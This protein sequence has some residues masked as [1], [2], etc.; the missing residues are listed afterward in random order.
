MRKN[1]GLK[2]GQTKTIYLEREGQRRC[3]LGGGR[4]A[5]FSPETRTGNGNKLLALALFSLVEAGSTFDS[6]AP[7]T[8]LGCTPRA[9]HLVS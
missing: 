7:Q 6:F 5:L 1:E 9:R 3:R 2:R 8:S 4:K